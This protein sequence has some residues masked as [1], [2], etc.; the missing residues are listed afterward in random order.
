MFQSLAS[1]VYNMLLHTVY[2]QICDPTLFQNKTLFLTFV[3]Y[4]MLYESCETSL[5]SVHRVSI[6]FCAFIHFV[7]DKWTVGR[8][9]I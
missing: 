8:Q 1:S 4:D 7:M 3:M 5:S 2:F 6:T 9:Y